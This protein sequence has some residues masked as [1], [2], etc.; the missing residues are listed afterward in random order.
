VKGFGI[1][2]STA[3]RLCWS[4]SI[5][6]ICTSVSFA[7]FCN[8]LSSGSGMCAR[9]S[10]FSGSHL[11]GEDGGGRGRGGLLVWS[12]TAIYQC[13]MLRRMRNLCECLFG[14]VWFAFVQDWSSIS[15]IF[16]S[17]REAVWGGIRGEFDV[18]AIS[19]HF[20][21]TGSMRAGYGRA[22]PRACR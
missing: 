14:L 16:E 6:P 12:K 22:W 15:I 5:T 11:R 4:I 19:S 8:F 18:G 10:V 13:L 20:V 9:R 1:G 2:L 17:K 7:D 3:L 21:M